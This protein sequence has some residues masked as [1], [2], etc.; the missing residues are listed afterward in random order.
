MLSAVMLNVI[1]LIVVASEIV[2]PNARNCSDLIE[3]FHNKSVTLLKGNKISAVLSAA[4][5]L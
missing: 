5:N 1:M 4:Q 3:G 2:L